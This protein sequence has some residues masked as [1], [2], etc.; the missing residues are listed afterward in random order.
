[1]KLGKGLAIVGAFLLVAGLAF[2]LWFLPNYQ[3]LSE[4]K[5]IATYQISAA[6]DQFILENPDRLFVQFDDL[7][8]PD[9]YIRT[10]NPVA[11]EDYHELFPIRVD[12]E[13]LGV[14][15]GD[16]RRVI[17][18]SPRDPE[19]GGGK[20]YSMREWPGGK[21]VA[22]DKQPEGPEFYRR[23][24]EARRKPD[25]VHT[26]KLW[27]LRTETTYRGGEPNGPFRAYYEGGELWAEA[28]YVKGRPVGPHVVYDRKGKRIVEMVFPTR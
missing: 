1:M 16:G 7:I 24:Q 13:E 18:F 15:M 9:K 4:D 20:R 27:G 26:S 12:F 22:L 28:T 11:G 25:G 2:M 5:S 14:T 3:R 10:I 6:M 21:I 8:G 23:W 19:M 17:V